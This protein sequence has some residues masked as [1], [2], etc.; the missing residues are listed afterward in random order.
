MNTKKNS[1]SFRTSGETIIARACRTVPGFATT[2]QT[3]ERTLTLRRR[4]KSAMQNYGRSIAKV[5]LSF[6][7]GFWFSV[8]TPQVSW[9][10]H[11][12]RERGEQLNLWNYTTA[13][14]HLAG[15]VPPTPEVRP[16]G[17]S[18]LPNRKDENHWDH[19][20]AIAAVC[21][22][23]LPKTNLKARC[24]KRFMRKG[25]LLLCPDWK[26]IGF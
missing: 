6:N 21:Y 12:A 1:G 17:L 11:L 7:M 4:S 20:V 15:S 18:L 9:T 16:G 14:T 23:K 3:F 10:A 2:Y 19:P 26:M 13:Q 8:L 22:Q 25:Q 5:A 24:L